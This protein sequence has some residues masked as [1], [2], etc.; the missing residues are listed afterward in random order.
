MARRKIQG[1]DC[2]G[3]K[4]VDTLKVHNLHPFMVQN[5]RHAW[6]VFNKAQDEGRVKVSDLYGNGYDDNHIT[7][8]LRNLFKS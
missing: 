5:D 3:C 7:T 1:D 8:A 4:P 6:D 2:T